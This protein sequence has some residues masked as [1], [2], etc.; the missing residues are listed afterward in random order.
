MFS[1]EPMTE[2][3]GGGANGRKLLTSSW[4]Y[5]CGESGC[6]QS[7]VWISIGSTLDENASEMLSWSSLSSNFICRDRCIRGDEVAL[8]SK[9]SMVEEIV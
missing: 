6:T 1:T 9:L 3:G 2:G 5:G 8:P 4:M 7:E